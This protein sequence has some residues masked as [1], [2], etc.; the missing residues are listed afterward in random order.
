MNFNLAEKVIRWLLF[1]VLIALLPLGFNAISLFTRG[2]SVDL[3]N[4]VSRG[5]LLLISTAICAAA[6]GELVPTGPALRISKIIVVGSTVIILIAASY[7]FADISAGYRLGEKMDFNV[8]RDI[9]LIAFISSVV[10]GA[11]CVI[12]GEV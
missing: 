5:E 11:L 7:Y 12:L 10:S 1:S 6:V 9:S 3:V 8:I 4:L 2:I